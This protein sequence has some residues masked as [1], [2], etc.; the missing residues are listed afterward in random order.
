M[1]L[2]LTDI[3][4]LKLS[5]GLVAMSLAGCC[6]LATEP[7]E[8]IAT[9]E[10][11]Y[12]LKDLD[13]HFPFAVPETKEAWETRAKELRQQMLV[14]L[15]MYPMPTL[16]PMKPVV[17]SRREM[18]GY[19]IE[20]VYFE[21]LPGL[22][23]TGS[24]YTPTSSLA[25]GQKRP[26]VL[27][28]HGH[29]A[30]GR[31]YYTSDAEMKRELATG[32]ERFESAG[33]SPLQARCVQMARMGIVVFHYDMM[34]NADNL[35]ISAERVHGFGNPKVSNP[36][37]AQGKWLLYSTTAEGMCQNIMGMQ[38]INSIQSL[39][40]LL[41][42]PDVRQSNR[43]SQ[44]LTRSLWSAHRCKVAVHAKT[45]WDCVSIQATWSWQLSRP[46]DHW[47]SMLPTIGP[48]TWQRMDSQN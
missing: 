2:T 4:R 11:K 5:F 17:H 14:S 28:P 9:V 31:F 22:F 36:D 1:K 44:V 43:D 19:A 35:Q 39:E 30:S 32:A 24:L 47:A 42:R 46:L 45:P 38:T 29:W 6:V 8:P 20:K 34:G 27:C 10:S 41:Q 40:F 37:V 21:S 26:A 7:T 23:V 18:D 12:A 16:A 15:G 48:R 33:R 3:P 13:G 25:E